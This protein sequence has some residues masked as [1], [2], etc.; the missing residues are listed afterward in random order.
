MKRFERPD[1]AFWD[2]FDRQL[3]QRMLQT[4]VR[5]EPWYLQVMRALSGRLGQTAAVAGAALVVAMLV[6]RPIPG[7]SGSGDGTESAARQA[8]GDSGAVERSAADAAGNVAGTSGPEGAGVALAA[9]EDGER[10]YA[11]DAITAER[12]GDS[13][14]RSFRREFE[15][16]AIDVAETT[17]ATYAS[18]NVIS[19]SSY[20]TSGV[21]S[22]VY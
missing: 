9:A 10:D 14:G 3:H 6:V 21:A 16:D 13:G 8:S 18:D 20:G 2:Q 11:L 15:M 4:L 19:R 12:D 7:S 17:G 22:L 5:K 1:D